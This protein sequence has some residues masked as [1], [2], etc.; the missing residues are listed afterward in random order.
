MRFVG[1]KNK[2]K[3]GVIKIWYFM[4]IIKINKSFKYIYDMYLYNVVYYFF[5]WK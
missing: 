4:I 3:I 2:I 1:I 5:I